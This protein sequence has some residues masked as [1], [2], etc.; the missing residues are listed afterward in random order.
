V[1]SPSRIFSFRNHQSFGEN[2][3]EIIAAFSFSKIGEERIGEALIT[4]IDKRGY[5]LGYVERF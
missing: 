5:R 1:R 3:F 4:L 2:I